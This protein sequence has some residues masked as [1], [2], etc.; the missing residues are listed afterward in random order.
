MSEEGHE[1]GRRQR[2]EVKGLDAHT[3]AP[4]AEVDEPPV[5]PPRGPEPDAPLVDGKVPTGGQ[6][7]HTLHH[8]SQI[9]APLPGDGQGGPK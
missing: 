9:V 6:L 4:E 2:R 1:L 3:I 5:Q 7:V 8:H